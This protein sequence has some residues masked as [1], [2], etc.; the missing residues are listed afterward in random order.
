MPRRDSAD[1]RPYE[2]ATP[3]RSWTIAA[4][5]CL[6]AAAILWWRSYTNATFVIATL[7][8]V[9]WFLDL[10]NRLQLTSIEATDTETHLRGDMIETE[11]GD[12]E[13]HHEL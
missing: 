12:K 4:C 5:L 13:H 1:R 2:A 6:L 9:A 10:R 7:V 8:V 11:Y 3:A